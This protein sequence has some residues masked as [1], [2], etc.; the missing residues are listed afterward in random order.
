MV[1]MRLPCVGL[2]RCADWMD[3]ASRAYCRQS[4]VCYHHAPGIW[5]RPN[6]QF[7]YFFHAIYLTSSSCPKAKYCYCKAL[8]VGNMK[9]KDISIRTQCYCVMSVLSL[10]SYWIGLDWIGPFTQRPVINR[11]SHNTNSV[12]DEYKSNRKTWVLSIVMAVWFRC[13][14]WLMQLTDCCGFMLVSRSTR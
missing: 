12:M 3:W 5:T 4:A 6:G 8:K 11:P 13:V 7:I 2:S 10:N 1:R 9:T 14:Q